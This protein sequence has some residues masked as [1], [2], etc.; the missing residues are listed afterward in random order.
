MNNFLFYVRV[1]SYLIAFL[2][3]AELTQKLYDKLSSNLENAFLSGDIDHL[4]FQD[5]NK[6]LFSFCV[7]LFAFILA[8]FCFIIYFLIP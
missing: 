2:I 6:K 5:K 8:A 3:S 1:C 4:S 7:L